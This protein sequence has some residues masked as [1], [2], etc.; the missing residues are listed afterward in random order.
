MTSVSFVEIRDAALKLINGLRSR[1]KELT[2]MIV[3]QE[4]EIARS[5]ITVYSASC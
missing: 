4:A 5:R 2:D 1:R 3:I